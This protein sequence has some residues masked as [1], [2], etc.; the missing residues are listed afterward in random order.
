MRSGGVALDCDCRE[1]GTFAF[2]AI[3]LKLTFSEISNCTF[4]DRILILGLTNPLNG[5]TLGCAL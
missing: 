2:S 4:N 1:G 3:R 5:D